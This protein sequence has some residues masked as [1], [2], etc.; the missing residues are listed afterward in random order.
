MFMW[1]VNLGITV[2]VLP[3]PAQGLRLSNHFQAVGPPIFVLEVLI[4]VVEWLSRAAAA[5][6]VEIVVRAKLVVAVATLADL[7]EQEIQ[8]SWAVTER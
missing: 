7:V 8:P 2:E 3:V 4:T 5:V 6:L 1:A